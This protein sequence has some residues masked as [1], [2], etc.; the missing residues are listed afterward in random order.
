MT[1]AVQIGRGEKTDV[2]TDEETEAKSH[3]PEDHNKK[4]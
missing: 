1:P 3:T 2:Y 4:S